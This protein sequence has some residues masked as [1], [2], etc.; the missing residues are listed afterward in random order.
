MKT[1]LAGIELIKEFES[2]RLSAYLCPANVWT[3]GWGHTE[4]VR[5][6]DTITRAQ[7][8]AYLAGDLFGFEQDVDRLVK[9]PL[10]QSQF[11]ALVSFAFNIGVDALAKSTLLRKLNSGQYDAVPLELARWNK[12][13]GKVLPGLVRRRKAEAELWVS[14]SPDESDSSRATPD[15]PTAKPMLSSRTVQGGIASGAGVAGGAVVETVQQ[16]MPA[17]EGL[18]W[19]KLACVLLIVAGIGL[20]IWGRLRV[21]RDEG[22]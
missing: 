3:I 10:T 7:A 18:P 16:V 11:D 17:A 15:A 6:G 2:L 1:S 4:G 8:D 13:G 21:A 20:T 14:E 22:V 5:K 19:L 12:A 9:V